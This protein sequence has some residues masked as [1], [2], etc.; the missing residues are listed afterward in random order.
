MQVEEVVRQVYS[1][2]PIVDIKLI[3]YN[4]PIP[5]GYRPVLDVNTGNNLCLMCSTGQP[6]CIALLRAANGKPPVTKLMWLSAGDDLKE[7]LS[8]SPM[9]RSWWPEDPDQV[10]MR[11]RVRVR[12][13]TRVSEGPLTRTWWDSSCPACPGANPRFTTVI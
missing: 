13:P 6:V 8:Q 5:S 1:T 2:L 11:V 10:R 9:M 7:V 12:V 3:D 4:M